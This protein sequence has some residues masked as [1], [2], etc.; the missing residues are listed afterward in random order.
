METGR[1]ETGSRNNT[2][3]KASLLVGMETKQA[4]GGM[5]DSRKT[6]QSV[7]EKAEVGTSH[8]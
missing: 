4:W 3:R 1:A 8:C 6:G 2:E 7:Y 5:K